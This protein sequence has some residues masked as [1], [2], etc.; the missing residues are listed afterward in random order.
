LAY[1]RAETPFH[2]GR[3]TGSKAVHVGHGSCPCAD[4]ELREQS[5]YEVSFDGDPVAGIH[6]HIVN[7]HRPT[8]DASKFS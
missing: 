1:S 6:V 4:E 2:E 8:E 7:G 5:E 3:C